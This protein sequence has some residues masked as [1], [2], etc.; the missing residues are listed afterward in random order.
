M[1]DRDHPFII[2]YQFTLDD[3]LQRIGSEIYVNLNLDRPLQNSKIDTTYVL[4]PI[5]NDFMFSEVFVTTL[6]IPEGYKVSYL[7]EDFSMNG[8][9]LDLNVSYTANDS[10]IIKKTKLD[11]KFLVVEPENFKKWDAMIFNLNKTYNQ[12][13]ALERIKN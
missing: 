7:P 8:N 13:L 12:T 3:Y 4:R 11:Y 9:D 10:V 2:N 1:T 5:E 6:K